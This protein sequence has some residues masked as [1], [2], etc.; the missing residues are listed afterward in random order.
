MIVYLKRSLGNAW[1]FLKGTQAYFRDVVLM[2]GFILFICLPLLGSM[3][4]LI[5][6]RGSIDYL[7]TDNI[8]TLIS[9]HPGVFFSLIAVLLLILLLVYF[10]FTFLLM[11]VYFIK[12]QEPIS[13]KQLLQLTI[14]QIKK[15]RPMIF[16]FF[17]AYFFLILPI[18][19]LSF[20]SDLL[21]K[22]KIPA[23]IMDFIFTNRWIIVSSFLLVYVFLGYIGIRLIFALPEMILRD[24][25]FREAIRESW[26][27]TKARFLRFQVNF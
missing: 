8:P 7:S 12:K 26:R 3:T 6:Q 24:R 17:L 16:L 27:L 9:Q 11:S 4:R 14:R 20:N 15:V 2:H 1:D 25:P 18:S 23:F 5:L 13:L 10:E 22:I 19:G 21:S